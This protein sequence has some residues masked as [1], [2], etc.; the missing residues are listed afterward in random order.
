[1]WATA[2][3]AAS[4]LGRHALALRAD[5]QR[6]GRAVELGQLAPRARDQRHP[7]RRQLAEGAHAA[8]GTAKIA[9]MLAR[10]AL[11]PNGSALSGPSATDDA[12]KASAARSTV[13]TLPGSF[14]PHRATHSGP[15]VAC[16][17]L[18]VDAEDARPAPERG[19]LASRW[20]ATSSPSR[21]LPAATRRA[22]GVQPA[23]SAAATRSSPLAT[24]RRSLSR[25]LRPASLRTSLRVSLLGG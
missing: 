1:M 11:G 21:P 5:E 10:T 18:V 9:P 22:T 24:K 19:Q 7:R 15:T 25:H 3:Q 8:T 20:G 4:D 12:P 13:P 6:R 2:S 23:A 16:V 14:T 17:A